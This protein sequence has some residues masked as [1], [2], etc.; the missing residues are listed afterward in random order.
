MKE[1]WDEEVG[2]WLYSDRT[3]VYLLHVCMRDLP[4]EHSDAFPSQYPFVFQY[5]MRAHA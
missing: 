1:K 3:R 5:T 2:T 4:I